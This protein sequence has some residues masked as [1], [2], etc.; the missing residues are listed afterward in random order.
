MMKKQLRGCL[1]DPTA[2]PT[3]PSEKKRIG[4]QLIT[5][6]PCLVERWDAWSS[7]LLKRSAYVAPERES[8]AQWYVGDDFLSIDK[9]TLGKSPRPQVH[10]PPLVVADDKQPPPPDYDCETSSDNGFPPEPEVKFVPQD[11]D[12]LLLARLEECCNNDLVN[13]GEKLDRASLCLTTERVKNPILGIYY[14]S[15]IVLT[16]GLLAVAFCENVVFPEASCYKEVHDV[17]DALSTGLTAVEKIDDV[18]PLESLVTTVGDVF[19]SLLNRLILLCVS[20]IDDPRVEDAL[21][22]VAMVL[23]AVA[24]T[25]VGSKAYAV[26]M[27]RRREICATLIASRMGRT[28]ATVT[29]HPTTDAHATPLEGSFGDDD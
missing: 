4:Y 12:K 15:S 11:E 3:P 17:L 1:R 5:F 21:H 18:S 29:I 26:K 10:I 20:V 9:K 25:D 27:D 8:E 16:S 28:A 2:V 14:R 7:S 19:D 24:G 23:L 13:T 6:R 22:S